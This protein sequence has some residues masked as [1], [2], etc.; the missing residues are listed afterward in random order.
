MKHKKAKDK[1]EVKANEAAGGLNE[2]L[3][4]DSSMDDA[5]DVNSIEEFIEIKKLQNRLLEKMIKNINE[6]DKSDKQ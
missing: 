5:V 3:I 6:S 1:D 2:E 4:I